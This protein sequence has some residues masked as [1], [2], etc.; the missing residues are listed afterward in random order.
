MNEHVIL[1]I[2][3]NGGQS[4]HQCV[5]ILVLDPEVGEVGLC[6]CIPIR[7]QPK[8]FGQGIKLAKEVVER[9]LEDNAALMVAAQPH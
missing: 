9:V 3:L 6:H 2:V 4:G 5:Q 1:L 7:R 8:C